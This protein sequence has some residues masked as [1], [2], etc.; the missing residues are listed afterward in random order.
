MLTIGR[1]WNTLDR[2]VNVND[3]TLATI[4]KDHK[5]FLGRRTEFRIEKLSLKGLIKLLVSVT[6]LLQSL[7]RSST[8]LQG[9]EGVLQGNELG[10]DLEFDP[11]V[12]AA[13]LEH[14][15]L[16][17]R[18]QLISLLIGNPIDL[19][20][21]HVCECQR[22]QKRR[23]LDWF[24]EYPD[25]RH[26]E[27]TTWPW[28]LKPS[29]AVLWGVC[30]MFHGPDSL[31]TPP[32]FDAEGNLV[33]EQGRVLVPR[34]VLEYA[35]QLR[36][37]SSYPP[38]T[39]DR[40]HRHIRRRRLLTG[41]AGVRIACLVREDIDEADCLLQEASRISATSGIRRTSQS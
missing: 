10:L 18:H 7:D 41:L 21:R 22:D 23:C 36:Q 34:V 11:D 16:C 28:S 27:S 30:W 14:L 2:Q 6:G 19:G 20:R 8:S 5:L 12:F 1:L 40:S 26:P 3:N 9:V 24:F 38:G 31:D 35:Q 32:R 39:F 33:D 17:L 4:A 15:L 29:L 25:A 13:N 37:T